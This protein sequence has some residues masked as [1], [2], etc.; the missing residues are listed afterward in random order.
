MAFGALANAYDSYNLSTHQLTIPA[1]QV[2]QTIYTNVIVYIALSQVISIG[3]GAPT[4]TADSYVNGVLTIPVVA[5]NGSTYTNVAARVTLSDVLHIGGHTAA[6]ACDYGS[7]GGM[8]GV[9]FYDPQNNFAYSLPLAPGSTGP[10]ALTWGAKNLGSAF[11]VAGPLRATLWAVNYPYRG[12]Q[13]NINADTILQATPDFT[14]PGAYSPTQLVA[15]GYSY[16]AISA[17][18]TVFTPAAGQYCIVISLE[19][20]YPNSCYGNDGYCYVDWLEFSNPA[21]FN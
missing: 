12:G 8:Y 15:G 18:G 21:F 20:Y 7:E 13:P 14:G 4:S 3:G 11:S 2:G 17:M 1:I 6:L 16:S 10:A 5:A 19:L 9:A